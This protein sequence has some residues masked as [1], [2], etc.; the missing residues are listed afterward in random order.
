MQLTSIG[1]PCG[2]FKASQFLNSFFLL[3][4]F[5]KISPRSY[6]WI[7]AP[8][9]DFFVLDMTPLNG[10]SSNILQEKNIFD[11]ARFS[12][13]FNCFEFHTFLSFFLFFKFPHNVK[14]NCLNVAL[15]K[16]FKSYVGYM[17]CKPFQLL[18]MLISCNSISPW[19]QLSYFPCLIFLGEYYASSY[20]W[21]YMNFLNFLCLYFL[22]C[23]TI[24]NAKY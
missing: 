19:K 1:S 4:F 15:F 10:C 14:T 8:F 16:V 6:H 23:A 22:L 11:C 3:F 9:S 21:Y 17:T 13:C 20:I 2:T 7:A 18:L 24:L 12:K 5:N